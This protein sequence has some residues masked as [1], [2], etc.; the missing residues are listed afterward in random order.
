MNERMVTIIN[1]RLW[2]WLA[3]CLDILGG[4]PRA[5]RTHMVPPDVIHLQQNRGAAIMTNSN[6]EELDF[7]LPVVYHR[8]KLKV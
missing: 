1:C 6:I 5:R 8:A 3:V 4:D 2:T 7:V